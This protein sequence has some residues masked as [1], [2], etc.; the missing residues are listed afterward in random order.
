M[1]TGRDQHDRQTVQCLATHWHHSP[2]ST[3][4]ITCG[5]STLQQSQAGLL[6]YIT[7]NKGPTSSWMCH[8]SSGPATSP[9]P[10][11]SSIWPRHAVVRHLTGLEARRSNHRDQRTMATAVVITYSNWPSIR[12]GYYCLLR[13]NILEVDKRPYT[14]RARPTGRVLHNLW[15]R[16]WHGIARITTHHAM[17]VGPLGWHFHSHRYITHRLI[18]HTGGWPRLSPTKRIKWFYSWFTWFAY[19][20]P[21]TGHPCSNT[22][23]TDNLPVAAYHTYQRSPA[24]TALVRASVISEDTNINPHDAGH[25]RPGSA[26]YSATRSYH[27]SILMFSHL[28]TIWS[29]TLYNGP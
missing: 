9:S 18:I 25:R 20:Q 5:S 8:R 29:S 11:W 3:Q 17:K 7:T 28:K 13:F 16:G 10:R 2:A 12:V 23:S 21:S 27:I 22:I 24:T 15:S 19:V 6:L 1:T 26:W 14:P 4:H